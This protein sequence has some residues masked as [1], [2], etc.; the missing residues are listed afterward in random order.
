MRSDENEYFGKNMYLV[1]LSGMG[2]NKRF[3]G[4]W[5]ESRS[6][7]SEHAVR[8]ISHAFNPFPN[9]PCFLRVRSTSLLK[10]LWGKGEIAHN[11]QFLLFPRCF[12]SVR[13]TFC[14]F[15]QI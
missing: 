5:Y 1:H 14:H 2:Q 4:S 10:T 9:K 7:C 11:E 12:L 3:C 6:D 15:H 8:L 13:I